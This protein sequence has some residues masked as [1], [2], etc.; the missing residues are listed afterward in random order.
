M[1]NKT[2]IQRTRKWGGLF[3]LL[4]IAGCGTLFQ[5][6]LPLDVVGQVDIQRYMGKWYEI[7]KYPVPFETGCYGVT[8]E[9]SLKD[10]GT[11]RVFNTCRKP[12]GT[13]AN[14]IEGSATVVD[15]STNAKLNVTFFPPFGAPY[16]IIDLDENYQWAVV[17]DPTRFTLW[18]LSRT[19]TLDDATYASI[20][21][22]LPDKGFDPS[23]LEL[24]PQFPAESP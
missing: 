23:R 2:V 5:S 7:S 14:T 18:I 3:L 12:D 22:R 20:V 24:M 10:D 17:S 1:V 4:P 11:V 8:A 16:W 13:I 6:G 15:S 21:S 19:P 9:Y